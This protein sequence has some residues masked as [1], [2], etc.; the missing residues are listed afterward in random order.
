LK[1]NAPHWQNNQEGQKLLESKEK[2]SPFVKRIL[3]V[4]EDPDTVL[5]SKRYL[6]K[7]IE[8]V[9]TRHHFRLMHTMT[10]LWLYWNSN[11][12]IMI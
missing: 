7:R 6:K 9:A 11:L 10:L 8:L 5:L 3:I 4:D 2:L 12:T 1:D